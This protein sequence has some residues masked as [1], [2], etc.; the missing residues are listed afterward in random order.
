MPQRHLAA[1]IDDR[2]WR[3]WTARF[4]GQFVTK[5]GTATLTS[6]RAAAEEGGVAGGE[7]AVL[8]LDAGRSL[9]NED[10]DAIAA[11]AGDV[12]SDFIANL[13][14]VFVFLRMKLPTRRKP[15]GSPLRTWA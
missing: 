3:A 13:R 4:S 11:A 8:Q 15:V 14:G 10:L 5:S 7:I 6:R 1:A 9:S 2:E 12:Q